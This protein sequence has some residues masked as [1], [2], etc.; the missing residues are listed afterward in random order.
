MDQ[1]MF[2]I[3]RDDP[4]YEP[5]KWVIRARAKNDSRFIIRHISITKTGEA[6]ATDGHRLHCA[7]MPGP[8]TKGASKIYG[9]IEPGLYEVLKNSSD[10]IILWT[11]DCGGNFPDVSNI[12]KS[13]E[14]ATKG[15]VEISFSRTVSDRDLSWSAACCKLA[16]MVDELY[17]N[18]NYLKGMT[19]TWIFWSPGNDG[20]QY[21]VREDRFMVLMPFRV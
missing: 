10:E 7:D 19:G 5:L 1:L 6:V 8:K 14:K 4:R 12:L 15:G 3:K 11:S 17:I 16:R 13:Y 9:R 21:L 2:R 20:C 18:L